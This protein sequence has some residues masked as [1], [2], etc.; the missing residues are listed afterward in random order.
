M[1]EGTNRNDKSGELAVVR[2]RRRKIWLILLIVIFGAAGSGLYLYNRKLS[3][4]T[5]SANA[6]G[7]GSDVSGKNGMAGMPV[8]N[9]TPPQP[10]GADQ[11]ASQIFIAPE[12]QQLIGVKSATAETKSV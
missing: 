3:Q 4:A 5:A 7:S 6:A 10:A 9:A 12:R 8:G 11:G 1:A 2:S